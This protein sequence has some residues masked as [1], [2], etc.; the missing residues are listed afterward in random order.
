MGTV[1]SIVII[2]SIIKLQ[3]S[4]TVERT[5]KD[6]GLESRV[7]L[8]CRSLIARAQ[9]WM[10]SLPQLGYIPVGGWVGARSCFTGGRQ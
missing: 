7:H 5:G 8:F 2:C 10:V 9:L 3:F 6:A 1:S 4:S